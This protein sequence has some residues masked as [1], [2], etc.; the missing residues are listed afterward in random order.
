M[1]LQT[2]LLEEVRERASK[3]VMSTPDRRLD[4]SVRRQSSAPYNDF[5]LQ[6]QM[7]NVMPFFD[8]EDHWLSKHG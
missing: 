7:E 4:R 2:R 5:N 1:H 8:D 3:R 6:L